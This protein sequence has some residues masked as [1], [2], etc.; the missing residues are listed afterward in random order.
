MTYSIFHCEPKYG[1]WMCTCVSSSHDD[2][3][4]YLGEPID[5]SYGDGSSW[6]L[7]DDLTM[8]QVRVF[9]L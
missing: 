4:P 3:R 7:M 6:Y 8:L 2:P 5:L 1:G 9:E